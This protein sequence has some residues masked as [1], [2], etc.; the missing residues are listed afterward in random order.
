VHSS[1]I[2]TKLKTAQNFLQFYTGVFWYLYHKENFR[3][4]GSASGVK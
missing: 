4:Q 3:L 2:S 1:T